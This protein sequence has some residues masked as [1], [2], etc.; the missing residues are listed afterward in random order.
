MTRYDLNG[1]RLISN[2]ARRNATIAPPA[3]ASQSP[4]VRPPSVEANVLRD[5]ATTTSMWT[6]T[7][8]TNGDDDHEGGDDDD[9]GDDD[10]AGDGDD[11]DDEGDDDGTAPSPGAIINIDCCIKHIQGA[12]QTIICPC[13]FLQHGPGLRAS[14][15]VVINII[16]AAIALSSPLPRRR[17]HPHRRRSIII[18]TTSSSPPT[19][20]SCGV[21]ADAVDT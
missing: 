14:R 4:F 8:V 20:C 16:A 2:A 10:E 12:W 17:N 9:E 13:G 11:D 18:I 1:K 6:M 21:D 5:R 15:V 19:P 7:M 3:P